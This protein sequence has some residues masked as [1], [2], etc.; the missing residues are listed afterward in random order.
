MDRLRIT[1]VLLAAALCGCNPPVQASGNAT[2]IDGDSLE[3]GATT[4]RLFGVDAPEGRQRCTRD[5][6]PWACGEAAAEKMRTLVAG[7]RLVCTERDIDQYGRSV[8]QCTNG[9]VDIGAELVRAG[10]ALAYRQFSDDYVDEE[11]EAKAARRGVWAGTFTPPWQWRRNPSAP[12]T[13]ATPAARANCAIKGNIN[14]A[15]ERIYHVPGSRSYAETVIDES[16][17]E[18]WFCSETEARAAGWRAPRG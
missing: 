9:E 4:V 8:A 10:L 6:A 3:I 12:A 5:G 7:R 16:R 18:R 2:V 11:A 13:A 14:R 17:G 1:F 15:G